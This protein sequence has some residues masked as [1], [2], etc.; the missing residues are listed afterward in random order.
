MKRHTRPYGCT[1]PDCWKRF[2]S[3]NDWHRH[4]YS[5]H[6]NTEMW[7]CGLLRSDQRTCAKVCSTVDDMRTHLKTLE[8]TQ[9]FLAETDEGLES[10]H[11]GQH[12]RVHFWCG[13]CNTLIPNPWGDNMM[14]WKARSKHIGNHYDK[15]YR[16]IEDWVCVKENREK[17]YVLHREKKGTRQG[18]KKTE[19][20][21]GTGATLEDDSDLGDD[22]IPLK[23]FG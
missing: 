20:Y 18:S 17:R 19:R 5:L 13:F 9:T 3:R 12:G 6:A 1:F 16:K 14:A 7:R 22:G 11:M 2:G 10:M 8:H 4:E 15:D 21:Y 23:M